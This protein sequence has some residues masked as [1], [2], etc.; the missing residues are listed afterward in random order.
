MPAGT[1]LRSLPLVF[2]LGADLL[3]AIGL[4]MAEVAAVS[5]WVI[6]TYAIPIVLLAQGLG[7]VPA[8]LR[9]IT[10]FSGATLLAAIGVWG[11][12]FAQP[13]LT[14]RQQPVSPRL[15][16]FFTVHPL[17]AWLLA[18]CPP[19]YGAAVYFS[20]LLATLCGWVVAQ[21]VAPVV[22]QSDWDQQT[23]R[24]DRL[25][26]GA[27]AGAEAAATVRQANPSDLVR[28]FDGPE[29]LTGPHWFARR[30]SGQDSK[31][32][33]SKT[34]DSARDARA[35]GPTATG[36]PAQADLPTEPVESVP[37]DVL[38]LAAARKQ[39]PLPSTSF[40]AQPGYRLERSTAS[41]PETSDRQ[42]R[43]APPQPGDPSGESISG[44][45][46]VRFA[47]HQKQQV[48]HIPFWPP[49][50]SAPAFECEAEGDA[51]VRLATHVF[52]YGARIEL[53]RTSDATH[54][55]TVSL[56]FHGEQPAAEHRSAA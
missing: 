41:G 53:K 55:E 21:S 52:P 7:L 10:L 11:A 43:G 17:L 46:V 34:A 48:V 4:R 13:F 22:A 6:P 2:R 14:R 44:S 36:I 25:L 47:A 50:A 42:G 1:L 35:V 49:F 40:P 33:D 15:A 26:P 3:R 39:A 54:A 18:A 30:A 12:V 56:A 31:P 27:A 19:G 8:P 32:T 5:A 28:R 45:L 51:E 29:P 37:P 16:A 9:P 20:G 38:P 23:P 24:H